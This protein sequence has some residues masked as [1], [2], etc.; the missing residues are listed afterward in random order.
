MAQM[1]GARVMIHA[2][3]PNDLLLHREHQALHLALR[4]DANEAVVTGAQG[5]RNV[6]GVS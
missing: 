1:F 2:R 3:L 4:Q 5:A 6:N